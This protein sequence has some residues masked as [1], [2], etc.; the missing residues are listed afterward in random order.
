VAAAK[1]AGLWCVAVPHAL[2]AG[3]DL[4]AADAVVDSLADV[5]LPQLLDWVDQWSRPARDVGA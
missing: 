1:A 2:T 4:S 3:L 5:T